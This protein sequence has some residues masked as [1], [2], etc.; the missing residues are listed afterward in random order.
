MLRA[1]T[2]QALAELAE[3]Q[4]GLFTRRQAE[5]TGLAWTTLARLASDGA[6]ERVAYGVYRLRGAPQP[7]HLALRAAWLQLAPDVPAWERT[8][9]QGV[10]SHR[11][12]AAL[13]GLGDLPADVHAFT[14]PV[15][16]QSRRSDVRLH[17]RPLPER[18][19]TTLRGGP[20]VTRPARSA[21]DLL[22]E[23]EDPG[24]VARIV[25]D[26]L[27]GGYDDPSAIAA[28]LAPYAASFGLRRGDGLGLLAW[29]LDLTGDPEG[30]T[31]LE[32]AQAMRAEHV[33][34]ARASR[35]PAVALRHAGRLPRR[36]HRPATR[37]R[38]A[39]ALPATTLDEALAHV[40]PLV[41]PL[42]TGSA[43]GSWHPDPAR[44]ELP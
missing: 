8:P 12:A 16:R 25:A 2:L 29:L 35:E 13:Y 9:A 23:R 34:E 41:D 31:W 30:T 24:A 38:R 42:L 36:A 26:A 37:H 43:V 11:S 22:G 20:P 3:E 18:G 17:H 4:G 7:D 44:W 27:R 6:A 1:T 15:R 21:A 28:V 40:R 19:W 39:V 32:E 33:R 14:L 5:A 10:V